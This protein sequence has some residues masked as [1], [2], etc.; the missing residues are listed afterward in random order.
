[1]P[2]PANLTTL[3]AAPGHAF[4]ALRHV[5]SQYELEHAEHAV[6][7][8]LAGVDDLQVNSD[9]LPRVFSLTPLPSMKWRFVDITVVASFCNGYI[10]SK[11]LQKAGYCKSTGARFSEL[12]HIFT[13]RFP[14]TLSKK[15]ILQQWGLQKTGEHC[16]VKSLR[17]MLSTQPIMKE[18]WRHLAVWWIWTSM[19]IEGMGCKH[20]AQICFDA[21]NSNFLRA[22]EKM[23]FRNIIAKDD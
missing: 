11:V 8:I 13:I 14:N 10:P 3:S 7:A 12:P 19:S 5:L 4:P 16:N 22:G 17:T 18:T 9:K 6:A 23:L 2:R 21:F 15:K 1:M 20:I